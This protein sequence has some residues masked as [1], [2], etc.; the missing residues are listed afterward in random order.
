MQDLNLR[1]PACRNV[2]HMPQI[3]PEVLW[4]RILSLIQPLCK[5][6]QGDAKTKQDEIV[7]EG[8]Q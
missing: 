8:A 7:P 2:H 1:P 5:G 4:C 3:R 6:Q